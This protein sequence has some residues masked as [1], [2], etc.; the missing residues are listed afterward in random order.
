MTHDWVD[1]SKRVRLLPIRPFHGKT[2][3]IS[4]PSLRFLIDFLFLSA[5]PEDYMAAQWTLRHFDDL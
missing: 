5:D 3:D 1:A 2:I 4:A